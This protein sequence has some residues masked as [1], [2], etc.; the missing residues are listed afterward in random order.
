M[1][2]SKL[3]AMHDRMQWYV[4]QTILPHV[5]SLVMKG[6]DIVDY[7]CFGYM[8]IETKAPLRE[9][10]IFR[11]FSNTK[12]VTSVAAL[13]LVEEELL[14]LDAPI[15]ELLPAFSTPKVLVSGA[16][17]IDQVESAKTSITLRHL[18]SHSAG[19]SYGFVDPESLIDAHYLSNGMDI[20]TGFDGSLEDMCNTLATFP[21]AFQ[22]GTG[23][24]YSLAT[25]VVA[26]LIEI[27]SGVSFDVFL[28][29]RIFEPLGMNDTG[30]SVTEDKLDRVPAM[31]VP[32]DLLDPMASGITL[33]S[34]VGAPNY[35]TAPKWLSGGG[36]LLSSVSDYVRFLQMIINE[37][38]HNGVKLLEPATVA[39][40]RQNQLA[41]GIDVNFPMWDLPATKFGLGFA[42]KEAPEEGEPQVA[43]GEHHWGGLAGTHSWISP[44]AGIT[45]FCGTQ[46][47]PAFWHPFSHDFKRMAYEAC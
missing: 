43:I 19:L 28:K 47:M 7:R 39:Q 20:L 32:N 10:A 38:Q 14:D 5:F 3:A 42:V 13:M 33:I 16:T 25:D 1:D 12:I 31:Y 6:T 17:S 8:D 2:T 23:W 34:P 41:P 22:P 26:R 4:D 27:V 46:V 11:I 24:R 9:D 35:L 45:G 30:F 15:A 18:L 29:Q 37:G 44:D 40:M 21:L 36:G